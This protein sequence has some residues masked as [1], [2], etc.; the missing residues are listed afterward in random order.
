MTVGEKETA[1]DDAGTLS[2]AVRGAERT[3][4]AP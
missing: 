1:G 3:E 2:V 4:S